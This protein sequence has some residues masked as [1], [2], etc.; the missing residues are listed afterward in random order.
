[1]QY[2]RTYYI[3]NNGSD[4]DGYKHKLVGHDTK[5]IFMKNKTPT[6]VRL[7][8]QVDRLQEWDELITTNI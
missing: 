8:S 6:E 4:V 5:K 1:M 3:E 7:S 2:R